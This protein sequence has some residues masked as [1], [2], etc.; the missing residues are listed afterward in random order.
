VD[1]SPARLG[2]RT[3]FTLI[4]LLVVVAIVGL[5]VGL[6]IPAVQAAREA[7]R[8]VQCLNNLK[9]IGLAVSTYHDTH[10]C[11]P[12]GM[13]A[14]Y[15]PRPVFSGTPCRGSE[16]DKSFLVGVLPQLEQA[17][18]YDSINQ[19]VSVFSY[20]NTTMFTVSIGAYVCPSDPAAR[21]LHQLNLP[22]PLGAVVNQF[23]T[24]DTSYSGSYGSLFVLPLPNS[25]LGCKV[26][27]HVPP[28]AN[29][30]LTGISPVPWSS[31]SDGL[32]QTMMAGE[33]AWPGLQVWSDEVLG[34]FGLWYSGLPGDT[35]FSAQMPPNLVL[36]IDYPLAGTASSMHPGGVNVLFCD[37]SARFVKGSIDSWPIDLE[38]LYPV[39]SRYNPAGWWENLPRP[40]VWQ[41]LATRNGAEAVSSDSY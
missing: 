23:Q 18:L 35:L 41:A 10:A 31:V 11:F 29:G 22:P 25:Q 16:S 32:S 15:D 21:Q 17:P 14:S 6:L 1:T 2:L 33:T 37:G 20:E 12:I 19:S 7:A 4:E 13:M 40:G 39:N 5:L 9:Q 36:R 38:T 27:P 3:A 26:D 28:Q 24:L 34:R 8:R 30:V